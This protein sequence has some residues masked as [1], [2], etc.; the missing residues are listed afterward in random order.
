[1]GGADQFVVQHAPAPAS[2]EGSVVS[3]WQDLAER[4]AGMNSWDAARIYLAQA[5]ELPAM[6]RSLIEAR[7]ALGQG[8]M[9][10]AE[11]AIAAAKE[12]GGGDPRPWLIEVDLAL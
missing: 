11:S 6:E 3:P 9:A 5:T 10:A 7:W 12:A 1:M 4:C 2:A 8:Q